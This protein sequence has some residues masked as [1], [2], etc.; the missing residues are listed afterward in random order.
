M[1][2]RS[3]FQSAALAAG[4]FLVFIWTARGAVSLGIDE[5]EKSN[6]AVLH[7]KR[8]G[9]VTNPSGVDSMGRSAIGILYRGQSA[10]FKL[11]KLFGPEHGIDGQT[12]AGDPVS[13][14]RDRSTGLPV[15]S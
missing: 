12:N 6:F 5:L 10:G 11:V 2:L 8:V 14:S 3:P 13:N 4:L 15:Y 9:L 7:G 1:N